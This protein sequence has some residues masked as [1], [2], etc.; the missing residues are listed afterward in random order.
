MKIET[1]KYS[2]SGMTCDHCAKSVEKILD[3]KNGVVDK[4]VRY[5]NATGEIKFDSSLIS[6]EEIAGIINT[7]H[8]KVVKEIVEN[9]SDNSYRPIDLSE[10]SVNIKKNSYYNYDLII[11]GGGSAAF[12]AAIKA[13]SLEKKVLMINDGLPIGG[14]CVNVGCVPSKTLIRNGEQFYNSN[15]PNFTAIKPGNNTLDFKEAIRQKTELVE[16]LRQGKYIDVLKGD[17]NV[18]ILKGRAELVDNK[19]VSVGH[20]I[21]SAMNILISTGSSTFIPDIPGLN[22]VG[23]LTNETLYDLEDLPEHL[24][25]FGGRYIALENAQLFSRLGAKVTVLQR[26]NRI[27][28]DEMPDVSEQ[29]TESLMEENIYIKTGVKLKSVE[30]RGEKIVI[31]AMVKDKKEIIEGSHIFVA[32]GRKGNAGNFESKGIELFGK[33]F[34][35][36]NDF[37]ETSVPNIYAAGDITG[38][39]L[40]V[41]SAA[42]E[43]ALA[44]ENMFS[45]SKKKKDYSVF[46][47]VVFT[48]PQIA[49]V[50][51]DEKQAYKNEIDYDV[52]T[53]SLS[54]VPRSLAARNT[55]GFIK[56]LRNKNSDKLIG[57]RILAP[58]GSELLMEISLAIKYGITVTELKNMFHP[59]LTLSE[60]VKIAAIS[61]DQDVTKLSCCAG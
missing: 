4:S 1:V 40:F 30:K 55:K 48:D 27:I 37:L 58:E 31:V 60:G 3:G 53:I 50:G 34:I 26:S 19:T 47:W 10:D 25:V 39:Y 36:T 5:E 43:G 7:T 11:I 13:S 15:N 22:D 2:I 57:A 6:K 12:S 49:G 23:Y 8:Y 17:E 24:I 29:L 9:G 56:L 21:Y 44:V 18:T 46:P 32:T 35:K 16:E 59:Y 38:E 28:P 41:Y 42:Y 51:M 54:D 52:S 33:G 61:F 45:D 20:D 14:S